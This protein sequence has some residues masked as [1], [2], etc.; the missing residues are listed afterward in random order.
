M[1]INPGELNKK[2]QIIKIGE[3][4]DENGFP[5]PS[6]SVVRACFARYSKTSGSELFKAGTE[7][8]DAKARF[9]VRYSPVE[10]NTDMFVRYAGKD[11]DI[12][13]IN[14]YG[15]SKEYMEIWTSL[16]EMA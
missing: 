12:E 14:P 1:N 9:L 11:Y 4:Q 3:M 2:I 15:D 5:I 8:S 10:I 6:E 16:R 7:F 13:Y